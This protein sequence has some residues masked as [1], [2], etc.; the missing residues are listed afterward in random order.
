M[1][2][3]SG[4]PTTKRPPDGMGEAGPLAIRWGPIGGRSARV[5]SPT[6]A[7]VTDH[8]AIGEKVTINCGADPCLEVTVTEASF[9]PQYV[10]PAGY[11]NDQP[12]TAGNPGWPHPIRTPPQRA[13]G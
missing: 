1:P 11:Y 3:G 10:D 8:A 2:S 9:V 4:D 7:P 13:R 5:P 12:Q 6:P